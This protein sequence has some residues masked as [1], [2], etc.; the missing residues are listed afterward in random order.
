MS[1]KLNISLF[2]SILLLIS[3]CTKVAVSP[4]EQVQQVQKTNSDNVEQV[5]KVAQ[6][7]VVKNQAMS[8]YLCKNDKEV[9]ILKTKGK[10]NSI[11]VTFMD[12]TH[13]LS[14]AVTKNGKKYSNIR[15]V[16][17]EMRS[18]IAEL[19]D[20]NKKVLAKECIKQR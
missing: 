20:N 1:L 2:I 6:R 11:N 18:G 9:R 16:W 13:T 7:S 5:K 14:P 19:Y 17:W 10:K 4:V 12:T 15:W 3:G 8:L